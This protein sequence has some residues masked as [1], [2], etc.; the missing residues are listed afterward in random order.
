MTFK[1][2]IGRNYYFCDTPVEN[3][4]IDEYM[5][6]APGEYV[7]V[8]IYAYMYSDLKQVMTNELVA[9][10]LNMNIEDVL[11]AWTYW[12]SLGIVRKYYPNPEDETHYEVEFVNIK[13]AVYTNGNDSPSKSSSHNS[14]SKM[15]STLSDESLA[16]LY[17]E[18][19]SITGKF[20]DP[21]S[22]QKI[23]EL[24]DE[25]ADPSVIAF[26]YRYCKENKK[27]TEF[28]YVAVIIRR[29][30]EKNMNTVKE[31]KEF[32]DANDARAAEQRQIARALGMN[33]SSVTDDERREFNRWI[34]EM[35]FNLAFILE[36]CSKSSGMG[37]KFAY[38]RKV[39]ESEFEK[40]GNGSVPKT[41]SLN[42]RQ[43]YYEQVRTE[44]QILTKKR[45]EEVYNKVP[46]IAKLEEE[47]RSLGIDVGKIMLKDGP[48]K[49]EALE[50]T[51]GRIREKQL[52]K[53]ELLEENGFSADYMEDVYN[54]YRCKDTGILD[55]GCHCSCYQIMEE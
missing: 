41:R 3:I 13:N 14:E 24:V 33:Y 45:R 30:L 31:I 48:N 1:R 7:K 17:K 36:V 46:Q 37:N 22:M 9:K 51:K 2:E 19:E 40:K 44:N 39:L 29:W 5:P 8:Y 26:A 42:D 15:E 10:R 23:S 55:D 54:C 52:E 47:T 27:P 6:D 53:A 25:G 21:T 34:D 18:I 38:V 28:R 49:E 32:I 4:F 11:A 43:R 50:Q 35:D 12:E 16:K 20:H